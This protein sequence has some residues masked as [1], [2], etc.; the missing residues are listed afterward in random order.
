MNVESAVNLNPNLAERLARTGHLWYVEKQ[1]RENLFDLDSPSFLRGFQYSLYRKISDSWK[2]EGT[3]QEVNN[4]ID[5]IAQEV[6][7][8]ARLLDAARRSTLNEFDHPYID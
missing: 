8:S 6:I 4:L 1:V 2:I 3:W 5:S 7:A